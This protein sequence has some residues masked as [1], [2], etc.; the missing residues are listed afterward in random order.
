MDG[1]RVLCL[2]MPTRA[3]KHV[4][5]KVVSTKVA[6]HDRSHSAMMAADWVGQAGWAGWAGW[7]GA[8][9]GEGGGAVEGAWW[10]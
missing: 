4:T 6:H 5:V 3:A 1:R 7:A 8:G 10:W 9:R 2:R